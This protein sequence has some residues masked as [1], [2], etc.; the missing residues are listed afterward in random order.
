MELLDVCRFIAAEAAPFLNKQVK[1]LG[2]EPLRLIVDTIS[3]SLLYY[4]YRLL[5][6]RS[7][8]DHIGKERKH[9][10]EH[11]LASSPSWGDTEVVQSA[12]A[13]SMAFARACATDVE[14]R[15]PRET[16]VAFRQLPG[17][18]AE[19]FFNLMENCSV[20]AAIAASEPESGGWPGKLGF[21]PLGEDA[22][23]P[24]V[25]C[26]Q[27]TDNTLRLMHAKASI[28][29]RE[30]QLWVERAEPGEWGRDWEESDVVESD[31]TGQCERN[32]KERDVVKW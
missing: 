21:M 8:F 28:S 13:A 24:E 20:Q 22:K 19:E 30:G 5:G 29:A 23:G 4:E 25:V 14:S 6:V 3:A 18:N 26:L 32:G 12:W 31:E 9:I 27:M 7:L 17:H 16:I 2:T 11:E 10:R 1:T 15:S